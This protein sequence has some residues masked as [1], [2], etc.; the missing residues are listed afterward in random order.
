MHFTLL[1]FV[2]LPIFSTFLQSICELL[3]YTASHPTRT[4]Q[5]LS[6]DAESSYFDVHKGD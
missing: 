4:I 5:Q 6:G 1:L 2:Y 3:N